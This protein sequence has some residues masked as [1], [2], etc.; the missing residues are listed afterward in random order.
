MASA[1]MFMQPFADVESD[2]V[3]SNVAAV[4][5]RSANYDV[6]SGVR[7]GKISPLR[8]PHEKH[9]AGCIIVTAQQDK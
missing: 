3:I 5:V 1:P 4:S 2:D 8:L 7:A 9:V 6:E